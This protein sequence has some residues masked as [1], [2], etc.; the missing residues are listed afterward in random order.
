[1]V[2]DHSEGI[3]FWTSPDGRTWTM[4][5][6]RSAGWVNDFAFDESGAGVAIGFLG[7]SAA[8][9]SSPD[10]LRWTKVLDQP[11]FV[12]RSSETEL[13]IQHVA[14]GDADYVAIGYSM[15]HPL[16]AVVLVST[17]GAAWTRLPSNPA[18]SGVSLDGIAAVGDR[19]VLVGHTRWPFRA[20]FW[21]SADGRTWSEM[22][23][24]PDTDP[25]DQSAGTYQVVA[26]PAGWLLTR[27]GSEQAQR[28]WWSADG[29]T[30]TRAATPP[31]AYLSAPYEEPT[32]AAPSGFVADAWSDACASGLWTSDDAVEWDCVAGFSAESQPNRTM[33]ASDVTIVTGD[34][35]G[36]VWVAELGE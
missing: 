7:S 29:T 4:G 17:D 21:T 33:A 25:T 11:A 24:P 8:A 10:G 31:G 22:S 34:P 5:D 19:Y 3:A 23:A 6:E 35:A 1:V 15:P 32:V 27:S 36:T 28:A 12:P 20:I 18:F 26:G 9:W 30:W 16:K 13:R 14:H 2:P